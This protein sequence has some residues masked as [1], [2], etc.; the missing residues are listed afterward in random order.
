MEKS[1]YSDAAV[2]VAK[3]FVSVFNSTAFARQAHVHGISTF[4]TEV[5]V[6]AEFDIASTNLGSSVNGVCHQDH[7]SD[8]VGKTHSGCSS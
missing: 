4:A 1:T 2:C 7:E 8:L 3:L 6:V 5:F